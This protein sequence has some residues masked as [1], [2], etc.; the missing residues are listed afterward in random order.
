M[1]ARLV[2]KLLEGEE[3]LYE[4][5]LDG[6]RCLAGK[7]NHQV[8]LWSRRQNLFTKQFPRIAQVCEQ[9]KSDTFLD[10]EIVALDKNGRAS[11]NLLQHHRSQASAIRY[12]IFDLIIYRGKSLLNIPLEQRRELLSEAL[13]SIAVSNGPVRL[14][15]VFED[16]PKNLVAAAKELGFEGGYRQAQGFTL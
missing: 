15:Q 6:Y 5:K 3:W 8:T 13:G 9:L 10:G 16:G 7:G 11:F 1:Y 2:Q 14:S 12:Y 4:V